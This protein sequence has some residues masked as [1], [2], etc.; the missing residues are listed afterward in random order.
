M[1]S[2]SA[3]SAAIDSAGALLA[4]GSVRAMQSAAENASV[5]RSLEIAGVYCSEHHEEN[6]HGTA[7]N[8][9]PLFLLLMIL[10]A[11]LLLDV[12]DCCGLDYLCSCLRPFGTTEPAVRRDTSAE[13]TSAL[14]EPLT[15]KV[16]VDSTGQPIST[17]NGASSEETS[18]EP[19]HAKADA[20]AA[21]A[22]VAGKPLS[23]STKDS[24]EAGMSKERA[25]E[26]S[27]APKEDDDDSP[28]T[29]DM[30]GWF[31]VAFTVIPPFM[32]DL[33]FSM[34]A[35]FFPGQA[36]ARGLS[37]GMIGLI[38]AMHPLGSILMGFTM[39]W[40]MRQPYAD[41]YVFLRRATNCQGM[42]VCLIGLVG[43]V[44]PERDQ[45]VAFALPLIILRF[46]QGI[47]VTIMEVC[48]EMITL[49]IL[50]RQYIGPVQGVIM[51]TRTL[52]VI[53]G[54]VLGGFLYQA[55]C[56][57]LPFTFG[58]TMI[59]VAA[60]ILTFGLGRRAPPGMKSKKSD[61][62]GLQ[63]MKT[64]DVWL[65][66]IP[67]FIVCMMT[68]FLEPSWQGFLGRRPF[69]ME[70]RE[71]G[72]FLQTAVM[73]Y[74]V[75][76]VLAGMTMS[77]CGSAVQFFVG[78]VIAS[79]GM[80]FIGPSPWFGDGVPMTEGIVL[81]GTMINYTGIAIVV[82]ATV[83]IALDIFERAGYSQKQVAGASAA[84]FTIV[85]CAG[86]A[87]GP[88]LGGFLIDSFG[89]LPQ[90]TTAYFVVSAAIAV[91]LTFL[92]VLKYAKR[93]ERGCAS[94]EGCVSRTNVPGD[95]HV[96]SFPDDEAA[97]MRAHGRAADTHM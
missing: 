34:L 14:T 21:Q 53:A 95:E 54:P 93:P 83:P 81:M 62:T 82:P 57:A 51:A 68:S 46:L 45:A 50:P 10:F 18:S 31:V 29:I 17:G 55:G 30:H 20:D 48:N 42:Y 69:S 75:V 13:P 23:S 7:G 87:I 3:G 27:S 8:V 26:G 44:A 85:I 4:P 12:F 1:S 72:V 41:T 11:V 52:G 71:I 24:L 97:M 65:V 91:P 38:F 76:L 33:Y 78:T 37:H 84:M 22:V 5:N 60:I 56:W 74:I 40:L 94:K 16:V 49:L 47:S 92:L 39:P 88:P 19:L 32:G 25:G 77:C 36:E 43:L 80:L 58:A 2:L 79:L 15:T 73:I 89:G 70:P 9:A 61:L 67:M 28:K 66:A 86:N 64:L 35:P 90:T 96:T 63:L 59:G 6:V